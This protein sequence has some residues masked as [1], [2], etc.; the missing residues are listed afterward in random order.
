MRDCGALE[1]EPVRDPV[2][3]RELVDEPGLPHAGLPDDPQE[4]ASPG[5]R[6]GEEIGHEPELALAAD[7][8]A[9]GAPPESVPRPLAAEETIDR[10]GDAVE[11]LPRLQL[12]A[13]FEQDGGLMGD[14][15]RTRRGPSGQGGEDGLGV[16]ARGAG[17]LR[18]GPSGPARREPASVERDGDGHARD[19]EIRVGLAGLAD[20]QRRVRRASRGLLQRYEAEGG[21]EPAGTEREDLAPE[22]LDLLGQPLQHPA[23]RRRRLERLGRREC[24]A[25]ERDRPRLSFDGSRPLRRLTFRFGLGVHRPGSLRGFRL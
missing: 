18:H 6:T 9:E 10:T 3:A 11:V 19:S 20:R 21:D 7:E 8:P 4:L 17:H 2:R 12:E 5:L 22:A 24:H 1:H 25:E 23:R 14:E 13:A 15:D 16:D